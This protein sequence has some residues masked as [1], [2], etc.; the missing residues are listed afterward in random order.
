M[1]RYNQPLLFLAITLLDGYRNTQD[2]ISYKVNITLNVTG[3]VRRTSHQLLLQ[4]T[5]QPKSKPVADDYGYT[6]PHSSHILSDKSSDKSSCNAN[7]NIHYKNKH[8]SPF[9]FLIT[10]HNVI[11]SINFIIN[12]AIIANYLNIN[13]SHQYSQMH[14]I[15][16]N[17]K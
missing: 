6:P 4:V 14:I 7:E 10:N 16:G 1:C 12:L 2:K 9:I 11:C 3:K 17:N 8:S 15:G 5:I 13:G